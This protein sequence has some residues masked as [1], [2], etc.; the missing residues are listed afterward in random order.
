MDDPKTFLS[1]KVTQKFPDF[2]RI[3]KTFPDFFMI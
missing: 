1:I 2:G 3:F